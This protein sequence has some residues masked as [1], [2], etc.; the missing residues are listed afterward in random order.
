M[1]EKARV[2]GNFELSDDYMKKAYNQ[3]DS[4]KDLEKEIKILQETLDEEL[5]E[6]LEEESG[7][8]PIE[9]SDEKNK[10]RSR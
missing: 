9:I 4:I 1:S 2:K 8:E 3:D 5:E 6:E 7:Q 10:R